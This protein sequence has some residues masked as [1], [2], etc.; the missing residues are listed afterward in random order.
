MEQDRA[1]TVPGF[2]M[3]SENFYLKFI[4]GLQCG[5]SSRLLEYETDWYEVMEIILS[6]LQ[7]E[8]EDKERFEVIASRDLEYWAKVQPGGDFI[9]LKIRVILE[10][11]SY[12]EPPAGSRKALRLVFNDRF[13][14]QVLFHVRKKVLMR[15]LLE[16]AAV[17]VPD[18]VSGEETLRA[19]LPGHLIPEVRRALHNCWT[20]RFFRTKI[21]R[22]PC[23]ASCSC[24]NKVLGYSSYVAQLASQETAAQSAPGP[25]EEE[26][27]IQELV[28]E[29]EPSTSSASSSS[30]N[31][32]T[33]AG[34]SRSSS[35][36]PRKS[37]S[38]KSKSR[39]Q[40]K[41][42]RSARTEEK[43]RECEKCSSKEKVSTRSSCDSKE[44][45]RRSSSRRKVDK[46]E[47]STSSAAPGKYIKGL[48]VKIRQL[49]VEIEDSFTSLVMKVKGRKRKAE[50]RVESKKR[51]SSRLNALKESLR[52]LSRGKKREAPKDDIFE[53][54]PSSSSSKSIPAKVSK[55]KSLKRLTSK[56]KTDA[57]FFKR[58]LRSQVLDSSATRK[59]R[60]LGGG[61]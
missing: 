22:A 8:P 59:K 51:K 35:S 25:E 3:Q 36:N 14:T 60:R 13:S 24:R 27:P 41:R 57:S 7:D 32:S 56:S 52:E 19:E 54:R 28:L 38:R 44:S 37:I 53:P 49:H 1:D 39:S 48:K 26:E 12:F 45:N 58:T 16:I 50:E 42:R 46:E 4:T 18:L 2:T 33:S 6:R 34:P 17:S 23:P 40:E 47:A 55:N 10:E 43:S 29:P 31:H 11:K 21:V 61:K 15:S 9:N 30:S 20:P 5:V